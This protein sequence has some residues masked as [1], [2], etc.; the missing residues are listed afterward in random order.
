MGTRPEDGKGSGQ[1]SIQGR[2]EAYCEAAAAED[3]WELVLPASGGGT[4]GSGARGR[5]QNTV[6]K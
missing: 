2:E 3:V 5:R 6:A 1:L 4:G